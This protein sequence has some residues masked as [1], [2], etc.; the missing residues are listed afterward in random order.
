MIFHIITLFPGAFD[1]YINESIIARAQKEKKIQIKFYNPR[2]F[3]V[4]GK[5]KL[6]QKKYTKVDGKPYGG[7]PGMV[8]EAMP[9]IKAIEKVLSDFKKLK[10][11]SYKQKAKILFLSPGGKQFSNQMGKRYAEKFTDIV[12]ICGRYEGIDARVK[13]IFKA[14][15][16]S[17]GP[18]VLT[19]GELGAMILMDSISRQVE[20]VLGNFASLEES[21]ISSRDVYTRPE[22]IVYKGKKYRVPK[23]LHSGDHKKIEEWK[24]MRGSN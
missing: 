16:I 11:K 12:V 20:G 10:A 3:T 2:E 22:I 7:G 23:V 15:E 14:E 1:S 19:G 5:K 17:V 18:Y 8:M 13:K 9:I 21:R 6:L 24:R 4:G